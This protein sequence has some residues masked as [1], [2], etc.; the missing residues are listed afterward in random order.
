TGQAMMVALGASNATLPATARPAW[1]PVITHINNRLNALLLP[2]G[3]ISTLEQLCQALD[4]IAA[5][6]ETVK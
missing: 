4:D 1:L 5:G 3:G 6:L 2:N